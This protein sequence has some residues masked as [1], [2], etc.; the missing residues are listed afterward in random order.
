[1][2]VK[3]NLTRNEFGVCNGALL[4]KDACATPF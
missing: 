1:M 4:R 2:L 3:A